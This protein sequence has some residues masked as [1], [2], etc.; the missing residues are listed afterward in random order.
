MQVTFIKN[1]TAGPGAVY[2][3]GDTA[4]LAV[5]LV[6]RLSYEGAISTTPDLLAGIGAPS[7]E[8]VVTAVQAAAIQGLVSGGGKYSLADAIDGIRP[9]IVGTAP[10]ITQFAGPGATSTTPAAFVT[11]MGAS[12]VTQYPPTYPDVYIADGDWVNSSS[13]AEIKSTIRPSGIKSPQSLS[14]EFVTD[15][16]LVGVEFRYP[17]ANVDFWVNDR[18]VNP[19]V[20]NTGNV[21]VDGLYCVLLD[22]TASSCGP[23]PYKIGIKYT[24]CLLRRLWF[25]SGSSQWAPTYAK[26]TRVGVIGDSFAEGYYAGGL[27]ITAGLAPMRGFIASTCAL[28]GWRRLYNCAQSGTGYSATLEGD[29]Y[30]YAARLDYLA[31]KSLDVLITTGGINDLGVTAAVVLADATAY[32]V[33]AKALMPNTRHICVAPF[34]PSS[35]P[36]PADVIAAIQSAA[37]TAGIPYVE[38]GWPATTAM[39]ID[40]LHPNQ[41]GHDC[42]ASGLASRMRAL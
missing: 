21:G 28:L 15:S 25:K 30:K 33:K 29:S 1:W 31:T 16:V 26:P 39:L 3:V 7:K 38:S 17:N 4:D 37:L 8:L 12:A 22:L 32:W 11:A 14:F 10:T 42:I 18:L 6:R 36:V 40:T 34:S 24:G 35:T 27:N 2:K 23:A 5:D 20:V 19:A 13:L 9:V 41:L